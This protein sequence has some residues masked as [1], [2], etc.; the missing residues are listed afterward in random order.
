MLKHQ[1]RSLNKKN[2]YETIVTYRKIEILNNSQ[3][4]KNGSSLENSTVNQISQST[5]EKLI[6]FLGP[7]NSGKTVPIDHSSCDVTI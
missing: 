3:M 6:F 2:Q 7:S 4:I 1:F 5:L